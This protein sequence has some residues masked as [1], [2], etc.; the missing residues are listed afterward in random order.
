MGFVVE[1]GVAFL[2]ESLEEAAEAAVAVVIAVEFGEARVD[3]VEHEIVC[4]HFLVGVGEAGVDQG[5]DPHHEVE[6]R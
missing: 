4:E 3:V 1:A 5:F 2:V 6:I